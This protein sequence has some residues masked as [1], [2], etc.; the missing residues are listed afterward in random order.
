MAL[1]D[2]TTNQA[3]RDVL[4]D[5]SVDRMDSVLQKFTLRENDIPTLRGFYA[6]RELFAPAE[7]ISAIENVRN[8]GQSVTIHLYGRKAPGVGTQRT[9][10]NTD[11]QT[12]FNL[13]PSFFSPI[14]EGFKVSIVNNSLRQFMNEGADKATATRMA[15]QNEVVFGL[16]Q[17][18]KNILVRANAQFVAFLESDK[19]ALDTAADAG[20][21]FKTYVADAK[22]VALGDRNSFYQNVQVEAMQNNFMLAGARPQIY[23]STSSISHTN[24]YLKSGPS[25]NENLEQFLGWWEPYYDNNISN[26]SGVDNTQ[27]LVAPGGVC[28]YSRAHDYAGSDPESVNGVSAYGE[29]SWS[30]LNVGGGETLFFPNIPNLTFELKTQKGYQDNFAVLGVDESRIDIA[31]QWVVTAQFGATKAPTNADDITS[32][33]ASPIIKYENLD[34]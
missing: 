20:D 30:L 4:Q 6:Q 14:V 12:V 31:K 9:R 23:G 11:G 25:N 26:G 29:D 1:T 27:Y 33:E 24:D 3:L 8:S 17:A 32:V 5:M 18:I 15:V 22:R 7:D 16:S 13:T 2:F 10:G 28:G 21:R 34:T 19:W